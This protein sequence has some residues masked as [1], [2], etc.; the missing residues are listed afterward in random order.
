[1]T[2]DENTRKYLPV[3]LI[4]VAAKLPNILHMPTVLHQPF[5]NDLTR[6]RPIDI[7][8]NQSIA[9]FACETNSRR[10]Q[11]MSLGE[12]QMGDN[13]AHAMN[14][15]SIFSSIVLPESLALISESDVFRIWQPG[16]WVWY[17]A[18]CAPGD[19]RMRL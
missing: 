8:A 5:R 6:N 11:Y 19:Q 12:Q 7:G 18:D 10:H 3:C 13:T 1:V 16:R 15:F 4:P 9:E 14:S 17:V 2:D